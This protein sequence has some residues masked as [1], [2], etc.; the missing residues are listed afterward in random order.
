MVAGPWELADTGAGTP[1]RD[2]VGM[3]LMLHI[4][5]EGVV[6]VLVVAGEDQKVVRSSTSS[7]REPASWADRTE[8]MEAWAVEVGMKRMLQLILMATSQSDVPGSLLLFPPQ[9]KGLQ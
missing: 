3:G 6:V 9:T 8:R 2:A 7:Q 1:A 5:I 4:R